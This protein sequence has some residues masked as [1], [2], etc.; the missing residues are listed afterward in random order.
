MWNVVVVVVV[1]ESEAENVL[2]L[3]YKI[4]DLSK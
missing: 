3:L 4:H 1:V 2:D